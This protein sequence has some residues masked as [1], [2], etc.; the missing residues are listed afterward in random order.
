VYRGTSSRL[1][2][3]RCQFRI[4]GRNATG[5]SHTVRRHRLVSGRAGVARTSLNSRRNERRVE[6]ASESRPIRRLTGRAGF[7]SIFR[8]LPAARTAV[9]RIS[10]NYHSFAVRFDR[11]RNGRHSNTIRYVFP[12]P[13]VF[14]NR[15]IRRARPSVRVAVVPSNDPRPT[16]KKKTKTGSGYVR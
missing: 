8:R 7:V 2:P 13:F 16:K 5:R 9:V 12:G 15:G 3:P 4:S 6:F 11:T 14:T 10:L 1:L